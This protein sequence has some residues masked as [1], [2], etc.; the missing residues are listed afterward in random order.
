MKGRLAGSEALDKLWGAVATHY[1]AA[2]CVIS[3]DGPLR[4][5]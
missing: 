1:E 3:S 4:V 2:V 5:T